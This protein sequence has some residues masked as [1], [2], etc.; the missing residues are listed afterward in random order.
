MSITISEIVEEFGTDVKTHD[1]G[2]GFTMTTRYAVNTDNS[3]FVEYAVYR[4]GER[5][6]NV[7][8]LDDDEFPE[9][10]YDAYSAVIRSQKTGGRMLSIEE[11][12]LS[13]RS[14][15]VW[16]SIGD[17]R[18]RKSGLKFA[19]MQWEPSLKSWAGL[20]K[21]NVAGVDFVQMKTYKTTNV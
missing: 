9:D 10:Q 3:I 1:L 20:K 15:D 13:A 14:E 2:A 21:Q 18:E 6:Q 12:K 7:D 8:M 17:T 11:G 19:G 4:N 5:L 16:Y